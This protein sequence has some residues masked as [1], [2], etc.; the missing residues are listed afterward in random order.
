MPQCNGTTSKGDRCKR[1]ISESEM[2]CH[3]H[4]EQYTTRT[5]PKSSPEIEEHP[6][7]TNPKKSPKSSPKREESNIRTSPKREEP[8]TIKTCSRKELSDNYNKLLDIIYKF[9]YKLNNFSSTVVFDIDRW[10]ISIPYKIMNYTYSIISVDCG[11]DYSGYLYPFKNLITVAYAHLSNIDTSELLSIYMRDV[12]FNIVKLEHHP[13]NIDIHDNSSWEY[14]WNPL[15]K[16]YNDELRNE[17]YENRLR[18]FINNHPLPLINN[19]IIDTHR[20]MFVFKL[21]HLV[22]GNKLPSLRSP[23]SSSRSPP[24]VKHDT[25]EILKAEALLK[26]HDIY[27]LLK[28][29]L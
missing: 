20:K 14:I 25:I 4:R 6:V 7:K 2:F 21:R 29:G 27:Y 19:G 11:Y 10:C 1:T 8:P 17:I 15:I 24:S 12:P 26:S 13:I 18:T 9:G 16:T 5:S 22:F 23:P 28:D 3:Q